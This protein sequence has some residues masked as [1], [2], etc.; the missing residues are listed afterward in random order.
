M[1]INVLIVE[2]NDD[3]AQ[4]MRRILECSTEAFYKVEIV[5]SFS[6]AIERVAGDGIDAILLDLSLPD[7][8][9]HDVVKEIAEVAGENV[10]L[11]VITGW[12]NPET[13]IIAK[14]EGADEVLAKPADP[15]DVRRKL[16]YH[17]IRRRAEI[18]KHVIEVPVTEM[19]AL[20]KRLKELIEQNKPSNKLSK[21]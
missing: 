21:F 6:A 20:I 13:A 19:S 1:N 4:S 2:D 14:E 15:I 17:V 11:L 9:G 18:D 5:G 7:G 8:V 3:Y 12:A 16:Q 10:A